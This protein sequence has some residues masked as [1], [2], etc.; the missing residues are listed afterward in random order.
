[1]A[2]LYFNLKKLGIT[3][4]KIGLT[5]ISVMLKSKD[6]E[7]LKCSHIFIYIYI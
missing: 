6:L 1:M 2:S 7:N 4:N 3:F 5:D